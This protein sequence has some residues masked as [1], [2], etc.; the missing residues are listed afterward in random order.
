MKI[1][2]PKTI[3][4]RSPRTLVPSTEVTCDPPNVISIEGIIIILSFL[5]FFRKHWRGSNMM[6]LNTNLH[7]IYLMNS[8]PMIREKQQGLR[9]DSPLVAIYTNN[10][11]G[12]WLNCCVCR[13]QLLQGASA[14]WKTTSAALCVILAA[15]R[16]PICGTCQYLCHCHWMSLTRLS[17]IGLDF[18]PQVEAFFWGQQFQRVPKMESRA[19]AITLVFVAAS[20]ILSTSHLVEIRPVAAT[21]NSPCGCWG[22]IMCGAS[23][24]TCTW[25]GGITYYTTHPHEFSL[26]K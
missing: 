19:A 1:V 20:Q 23:P 15:S 8:N 7:N 9:Q 24:L 26:F 3:W 16:P 6:R 2:L 10:S 17:C 21:T 4:E 5:S 12:D 14:Q 11:Y 18:P 13:G 25:W 22:C